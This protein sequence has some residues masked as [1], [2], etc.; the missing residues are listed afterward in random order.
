MA[1]DIIKKPYNIENNHEWVKERKKFY[2]IDKNELDMDYAL[3]FYKKI[4]EKQGL[5]VKETKIV[6]RELDG[7]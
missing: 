5:L 1:I 2:N 3:S 4:L 6:C 7:I